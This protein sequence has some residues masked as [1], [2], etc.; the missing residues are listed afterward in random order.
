[1]CSDSWQQPFTNKRYLHP[2]LA[3]NMFTMWPELRLI[4]GDVVEVA[5]AFRAAGLRVLVGEDMHSPDF[6]AVQYEV[7]ED[8]IPVHALSQPC[9]EYT[10]RMESFCDVARVPVCYTEFALTNETD[11]A[12]EDVIVLLPRTGR[13]DH[14]VGTEVDGYAHYDSNVY[15]WG[16]LPSEWQWEA[17]IL[18]DAEYTVRLQDTEGF[19]IAWQGDVAGLEW[20]QRRVLRM[21]FTLQ[22]GETKRFCCAFRHG[23]VEPFDYEAEKSRTIAFWQTELARLRRSPGGEEYRPMINNLTAQSLQ[24]FARPVGRD[25]VFPRQ[26]GLQRVIWPNEAVEFLVALDRL[27]DFRRYTETAYDSFFFVL[28]VKEGEDIGAVQNLNGN[29]WGSITGASVW[30]CARSLLF[31]DDPAAFDKFKEPLHQAFCWMERQRD[32]TR[33]GSCKGVGIFPPM[34]SSD[35]PGEF[36]SWTFTDAFNLLGYEWLANVF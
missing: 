25:F 28:Q 26:G 36:Q 3:E 31:W 11:H 6:K 9:G 22:A 35:W 15:N 21:R 13:E 19:D 7:R 27:G 8:G 18:A 1:M 33:D 32:K 16:F 30:G 14:L 23:A 10:I 29:R 17:P 4:C 24:M 5:C 34:K 12:V 2:P 20:Y